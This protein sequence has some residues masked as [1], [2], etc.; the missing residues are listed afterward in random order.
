MAAKFSPWIPEELARRGDCATKAWSVE[1]R[2]HVV[3]ESTL[4][5]PKPKSR[6]RQR[7]FTVLRYVVTV[8]AVAYVLAQITW[9]DRLLEPDGSAGPWGWL[10]WRSS[11]EPVFQPEAGPA[12][13]L[14]LAERSERVIPGFIT[15]LKGMNV[16]IFLAVTVCHFVEYLLLAFRWQLLLRTH[17]LDPGFMEAV[18]LTWIGSLTNNVLPS[19]TGGDLVKGWCIFRRTPGKRIPAVMTVFIDRVIGL[20]SLLGIGTVAVLLQT[21]RPELA[22]ISRIASTVLLAVLLGAMA[23]FSGRLRRLLRVAEIV[24]RLPM[25]RQL[26]HLDDSV[27]HYRGHAPVVGW[28]AAISVLVHS[29]LFLSIYFLSVA[30]GLSISVVDFFIFLPIIFLFAAV[31]PSIAGLGVLEGSFAH[32]FS[33]PGIGATP[34]SAVALCVL[35]RI[36]VL[37]CALPGAIPTYREFSMHG[38][39]IL[40][41]PEAEFADEEEVAISAA[42]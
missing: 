37:L 4:Q 39:R 16:W 28:C 18:R 27:F 13:P 5:M 29:M 25:G 11:G 10:E 41:H 26:K 30:I 33:L 1:S 6:W 20:I 22:H 21:S 19:S 31:V 32:F 34:S 40:S 14:T 15:L 42:G 17:G 38:V 9:R 35:Y 23:F 24:D 7:F 12:I 2:E 8:A 36:V 3:V